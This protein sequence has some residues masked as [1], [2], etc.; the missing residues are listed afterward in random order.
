MSTKVNYWLTN[1]H[2]G[3]GKISGYPYKVLNVLYPGKNMIEYTKLVHAAGHW[4][5]TR[6]VLQTAGISLIAPSNLVF[7]GRFNLEFSEDAKMRFGWFPGRC[8]SH[9]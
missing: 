3:Q 4:A 2:T 5:G 8:P 6:V 9:S 7:P 1:H